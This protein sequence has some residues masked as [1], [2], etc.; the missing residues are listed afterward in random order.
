MATGACYYRYLTAG[1]AEVC[2]CCRD[3]AGTIA[4]PVFRPCSTDAT[5]AAAERSAYN[6]TGRRIAGSERRPG[7]HHSCSGS[8]VGCIVMTAVVA[9][10]AGSWT[11]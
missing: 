6:S 1:F 5:A 4:A 7:Y 11:D 3:I 8:A 10:D 2:P 9:A